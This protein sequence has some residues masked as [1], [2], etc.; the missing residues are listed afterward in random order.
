M[1]ERTGKKKSRLESWLKSA[2]TP[3]FLVS[4]TRRVLF[5]NTGCEQLTGWTAD[6]VVGEVAEF[7]SDPEP[8]SLTAMINSLCPPP[9]V[10]TGREQDVPVFL[11][12]KKGTPVAKLIR[13]VPITEAERVTS[14]LGIISAL[15]VASHNQ[16][17]SMALRYHAELSALRWTLKQR[18]GL[19]TVV[20]RS[21][22]MKRVFEQIQLARQ[23]SVA[24]HFFG[25]R[26][27]GKEHFAR[28]I[29]HEVESSFGAFV[30]LDCRQSP[31]ELQEILKRL[32]HPQ[33]DDT[34]TTSQHPRTL[35]LV[36][37][38]HLS[39][40]VQERLLTAYR[41]EEKAGKGR[42]QLPRLMSSSTELLQIAVTEERLLPELYFLLTP[43]VIE[44]PSLRKRIDDLEPLAQA[45]L[46]SLNRGASQQVTGFADSVW[47]QLREYQWP[48]NLDELLLVVQEAR[49]N[50]SGPMI[51]AKDLP[52]RFRAGLDAQSINP[53]RRNLIEEPIPHLEAH[54][55]AVERDLIRRA[56]AQTKQNKTQ[57]AKL[58]GIPR[59]VL[60]RRMAALGLAVL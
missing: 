22:V 11:P 48:G 2:T 34:P 23:T 1:H 39:R 46:E 49:H 35:F 59:P 17:T 15:P 27:V 32:L 24:V 9:E 3:V 58:L 36:D 44:V 20:A 50:G 52:L 53:V 12:N 29:H 19:K 26:G 38:A 40:D 56:L 45:F 37:V 42:P 7:V 60:Y 8:H 28:A 6:E 16:P 51:D 14:V 25:P 57:A 10:M 43:L 13:F 41:E 47:P 31:Y 5:F 4:V 18:Y 55:A 54:L 33:A 30:P 21:L